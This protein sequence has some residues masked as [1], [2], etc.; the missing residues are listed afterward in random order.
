M[1]LPSADVHRSV[2]L[3]SRGSF[4]IAPLAGRSYISGR[5]KKKKRGGVSYQEYRGEPLYESEPR[6]T[7][8]RLTIAQS[9]FF[10]IFYGS[11]CEKLS[12]NTSFRRSRGAA[13]DTAINSLLSYSG[14]LKKLFP[15]PVLLFLL[16]LF[17]RFRRNFTPESNS[18]SL[19]SRSR[20][21]YRPAAPTP[22]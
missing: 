6:I 20:N 16:F 17:L 8:L 21:S 2:F 22:G 10:Y 1:F 15:L 9:L 3:P 18:Q 5:G 11:W 4:S 7:A 13:A 14:K 19:C 12:V